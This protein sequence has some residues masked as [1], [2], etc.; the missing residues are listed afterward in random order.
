VEGLWEQWNC[1]RII[2]ADLQHRMRAD[3]SDSF[4][5]NAEMERRLG[6]MYALEDDILRLPVAKA[7]AGYL[8]RMALYAQRTES[9]EG[10]E[11]GANWR[12]VER[13][14]AAFDA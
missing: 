9:A 13:A 2:V 11:L 7:D 6:R 1:E 3:S 12:L 5:L 14:T 8:L 4:E 10:E